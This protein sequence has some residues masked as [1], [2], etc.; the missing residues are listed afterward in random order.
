MTFVELGLVV[1][2]VM[3][4]LV[5]ASGFWPY[6]V[7]GL[8]LVS[9]AIGSATYGLSGLVLL[10]AGRFSTVGSLSLASVVA[11]G[12]LIGGRMQRSTAPLD[13]AV[14]AGAYALVGVATVSMIAVTGSF[15]RLTPDSMVYLS[16]SGEL[17]LLGVLRDISTSDALKRQFM[18]AALQAGG[19]VSGRGYM[20]TLFPVVV[21]SGLG[22]T[23][24]LGTTALRNLGLRAH[25]I[26]LAVALVGL[27]LVTTNRVVYHMFYI[28]SHGIFATMLVVAVGLLWLMSTTRTWS[29]SILVGLAAAAIVPLRA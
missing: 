18:M 2:I 24:W 17:E 15:T 19:V 1:W 23:A 20:V 28:N 9:P 16:L 5:V 25:K 3:I 13:T 6:G 22:F 7:A 21:T 29:Q 4:G 27:F 10:S 11:V 8:A 12:L 14:W 26:A